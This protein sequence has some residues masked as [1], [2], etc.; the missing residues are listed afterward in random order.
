[1]RDNVENLFKSKIEVL[2]REF[3]TL[4]KAP[5]IFPWNANILDSWAASDAPSSG[6]QYAATFILNVWDPSFDWKSGKFEV[7][8][9][10]SVWDEVHREAFLKWATNPWWP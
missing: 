10:L 7:V 9:A 5:G 8:K 3:P 2:S 4:I 1:M 6:Q